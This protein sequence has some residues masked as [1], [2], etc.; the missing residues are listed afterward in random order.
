MFPSSNRMKPNW[1]QNE[2]NGSKPRTENGLKRTKENFEER[3]I[4]VKSL[5]LGENDKKN[6]F[7]RQKAS[8][9]KD[10]TW[11]SGKSGLFNT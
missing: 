11:F 8:I 7:F 4:S 5:F 9:S 2:P 3:Q 1:S 6:G 10:Y